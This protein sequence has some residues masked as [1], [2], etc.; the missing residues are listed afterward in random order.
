MFFIKLLKPKPRRH[1]RVAHPTAHRW[2]PCEIC[3]VVEILRS[4]NVSDHEV[5]GKAG[6]DLLR[7]GSARYGRRGSTPRTGKNTARP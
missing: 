5:V 1:H 7:G 4:K 2:E 3:G 6:D